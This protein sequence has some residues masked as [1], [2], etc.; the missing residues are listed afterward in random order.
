MAGREWSGHALFR[1]ERNRARIHFVCCLNTQSERGCRAPQSVLT[2]SCTISTSTPP[3][4]HPPAWMRIG[5]AQSRAITTPYTPV[6]AALGAPETHAPVDSQ[7]VH[8]PQRS[9]WVF[10]EAAPSRGQ[11]H[12][13]R[14]TGLAR[15]APPGMNPLHAGR[16]DIVNQHHRTVGLRV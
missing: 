16:V 4:H 11:G 3:L 2:S 12:V 8:C 10:N 1:W 6:S 14:D 5:L 9:E 7:F 15:S 13:C